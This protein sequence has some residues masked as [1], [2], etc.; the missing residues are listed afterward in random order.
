[1]LVHDLFV[2]VVLNHVQKIEWTL[3]RMKFLPS[4]EIWKI[5]ICELKCDLSIF[6]LVHYCEHADTFLVLF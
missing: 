3:K 4:I 1:L 2:G 5:F 6:L